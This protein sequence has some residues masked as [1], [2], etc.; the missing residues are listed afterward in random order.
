MKQLLRMKMELACDIEKEK[1]VKNN[2]REK[3]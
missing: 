2:I 3:T 1:N